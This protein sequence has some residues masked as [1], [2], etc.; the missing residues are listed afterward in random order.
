MYIYASAGSPK[1]IV[2][3]TAR[4]FF[5]FGMLHLVSTMFI[6]TDS[7]KDPEGGVFHRLLDPMGLGSMIDA[8]DTILETLVGK[9][10]LKQFIRPKRN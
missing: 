2:N 8:I 6:T 1:L 3:E 7:G 4:D 9:T 10:T 5:T